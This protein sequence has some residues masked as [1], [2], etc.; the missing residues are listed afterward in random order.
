MMLVVGSACAATLRADHPDRYI[1][2]KGD[3]LW[4]VAAR[5]LNEPWRWTEIWQANPQIKNPDLI[6][7]GDELVLRTQADGEPRIQ[8]RRGAGA[9]PTVKLSPKTRA[10]RLDPN[11]ISPIPIDA[12][13]PFLT[14][15]L[16]VEE[17]VF[18][19]APYVLSASREGLMSRVGAKLYARGLT[20]LGRTKYSIYRR[21]QP[22]PDPESDAGELLGFEAIHLGDA[23]LVRAG[24]PA[25]LVLT[26]GLGAIVKGDRLLPAPSE[27]IVTQFLPRPPGFPASGQIVA[28]SGGVSQIGQYG[29]VV[30]NRGH[31]HGLVIGHV[32]AVYQ[33]GE[34]INDEQ[35]PPPDDAPFEPGET[36]LELDPEKQGGGEGLVHAMH[37]VLADIEYRGRRFLQE[38]NVTERSYQK[39]QIP[40]R[41]AGTLI[42]FRAFDRL[43]YALV[44][45]ATRAMH[46][47]DFVGNP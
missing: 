22:Y 9:R 29:V 27:D 12:I 3:T 11:A 42:V 5:F 2:Q 6:Y 41:R 32:M 37:D 35:A 25:T 45:E 10:T 30:L 40:S 36:Y 20:D 44:M 1:V 21:G 15:P 28:V 23:A 13:A 33:R 47:N 34:S 39:V 24:D 43:S 19:A 31:R 26:L 7:V 4:N 46:V 8:V 16:V 14:R 18:E 17:G 38:T